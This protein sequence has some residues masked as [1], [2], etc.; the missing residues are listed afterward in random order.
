MLTL[1][2]SNLQVPILAKSIRKAGEL[3]A[4]GIPD[5]MKATETRDGVPFDHMKEEVLPDCQSD[6]E[7][8]D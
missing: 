6:G 5:A 8:K 2:A 7:E 1:R 4:A 3:G